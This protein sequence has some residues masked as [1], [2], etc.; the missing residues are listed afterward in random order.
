[1]T[2]GRDEQGLVPTVPPLPA[3]QVKRLRHLLSATGAYFTL[4]TETV[5]LAWFAQ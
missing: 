5:L 2:V 4:N 1:M 3:C